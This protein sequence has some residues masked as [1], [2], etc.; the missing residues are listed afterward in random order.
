MK[1]IKKKFKFCYTNPE[2][3]MCSNQCGL[4][5]E[6]R[7][8]E[9]M[10]SKS[11]VINI[12]NTRFKAKHR[13]EDTKKEGNIRFQCPNVKCPQCDKPGHFRHQCHERSGYRSSYFRNQH[14]RFNVGAIGDRDDYSVTDDQDALEIQ[15]PKAYAL[16]LEEGRH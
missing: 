9:R 2:K 16:Q 6:N 3:D 13:T 5:K 8:T 14:S 10:T 1:N 12:T 7:S 15:H 11:I 4:R